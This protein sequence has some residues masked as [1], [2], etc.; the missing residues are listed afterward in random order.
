[1]TISRFVLAALAL[2]GLSYPIESWAACVDGVVA[3]CTRNGCR[4]VSECIGGRF[5][6]CEVAQ[7]CSNPPITDRIQ[8]DMVVPGTEVGI[9]YDGA[10]SLSSFNDRSRVMVASTTSASASFQNILSPAFGKSVIAF[11]ESRQPRLW[12]ANWTSSTNT[13]QVPLDNN[14]RFNVT[15]WIAS[16]NFTT[17]QTTAAA[18]IL[19]LNNTYKTEKAGVRVAFTT[20]VDATAIQGAAAMTELNSAQDFQSRI[21]FN[22]RE[23]NIYVV[24]NVIGSTRAGVNYNGTP[25]IVLGQNGLI[26]RLMEHEIGHAF[27][28]WHVA[29]LA[30]FNSEN[31][32]FPIVSN[33]FLSEG[34]IFRMH[35]HPSSQ[36][37]VFGLRPTQ[38]VM[39]CNEPATDECPA[40]SR[41]LWTDGML[42]PN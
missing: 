4:G 40:N 34:Q 25:V 22:P 5:V 8:V 35:F 19:A 2:C 41:R 31:V 29:G 7:Q 20:F 1:M 16:G 37:N 14:L 12:P 27:V 11:G 9:L 38:R 42:P 39:V 30:D 28:L 33:S 24:D 15:V 36:L 17:Q 26:A 23:I 32:M 3:S 21:G 10:N 6:G 18:A 13:I